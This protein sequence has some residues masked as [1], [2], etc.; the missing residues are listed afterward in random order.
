MAKMSERLSNANIVLAY[1]RTHLR[2]Y[3][4]NEFA[5]LLLV[6][7]PGTFSN[8]KVHSAKARRN[9]AKKQSLIPLIRVLIDKDTSDSA[10]SQLSQN[11]EF[12]AIFP[13]ITNKLFEAVTCNPCFW[14]RFTLKGL[15]LFN[16]QFLVPPVL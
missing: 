10:T 16:H 5:R 8:F 9:A 13:A 1:S 4:Y 11:L 12:H 6:L 2:H 15:I 14:L 7:L 3:L